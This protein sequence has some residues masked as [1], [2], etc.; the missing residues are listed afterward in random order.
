MQRR[1]KH[2]CRYRM[3]RQLLCQPLLHQMHRAPRPPVLLPKGPPARYLPGNQPAP[4]MQLLGR[5]PF[6]LPPFRPSK[7]SQTQ[8]SQ[9]VL[10]PRQHRPRRHFR[11]LMTPW[12]ERPKR[13]SAQHPV[14]LQ[15][16]SF[17]SS[18]KPR[19]SRLRSA[20]LAWR[21]FLASSLSRNPQYH[22]KP[23]PNS[24]DKPLRKPR[25][26]LLPTRL[27]PHNRELRGLSLRVLTRGSRRLI[28]AR[29]GVMRKAEHSPRLQRPRNPLPLVRTLPDCLVL[30]KPQQPLRIGRMPLSCRSPRLARH[31]V[32]QNPP[33]RHM[34]ICLSPLRRHI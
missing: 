13:C 26:Q 30:S 5:R 16:R 27:R 32:R 34:R 3:P 7:A 9:R 19:I 29:P 31:R 25:R 17:R 10:L 22:R 21:V 8:R 28:K 23:R 6:R 18:H 2:P 20:C 11:P 1:N 14:R 15:R 33:N 12:I 4:P 24:Q